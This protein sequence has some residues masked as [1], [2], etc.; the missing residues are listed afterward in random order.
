MSSED[1]DSSG[2]QGDDDGDDGGGGG[3]DGGDDG[4]GGGDDGGDDVKLI[5]INRD[6]A[7]TLDDINVTQMTV[8]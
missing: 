4:G 6:H 3:D 5:N 7:S 8:M 1:K 2:E